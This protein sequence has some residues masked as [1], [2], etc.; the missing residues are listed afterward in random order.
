METPCINVC[1]INPDTKLCEGCG[2]TIAEI[3]RWS[4]L[5]PA[6]RSSIMSQLPARLKAAAAK[7]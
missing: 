7:E 4:I 1:V 6:E 3:S 5:T 2:R